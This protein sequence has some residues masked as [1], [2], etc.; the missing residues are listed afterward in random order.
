MLASK[1]LQILLVGAILLG[2]GHLWL[3]R[4]TH[5]TKE[6]LA[7]LFARIDIDVA[8]TRELTNLRLDGGESLREHL[9]VVAKSHA[10]NPHSRPLHIGQDINHWLLDSVV[11]LCKRTFRLE[12]W[13][14]LVEELQCDIG[15]LGSI[16]RHTIDTHH[17]HSELLYTLANERLY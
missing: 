14:Q 12:L 10:V 2:L 17:I 7:K 4:N 1:G 6:H 15:I 3:G 11:E 9:R 8:F 16:L 13:A 5:L